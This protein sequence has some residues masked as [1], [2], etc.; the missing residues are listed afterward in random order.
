MSYKSKAVLIEEY[1]AKFGKEP[2]PE[3]TREE[4]ETL[5]EADPET[6]QGPGP[7]PLEDLIPADLGPNEMEFVKLDES[8]EVIDRT[9]MSKESFALLADHKFGWT[10]AP[11][12]EIE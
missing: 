11:P 2:L 9:T 8:G 5:L 7:D 1:I 6:P 12:K 10:I 3:V 4:L